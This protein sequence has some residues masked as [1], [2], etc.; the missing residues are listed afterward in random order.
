LVKEGEATSN[1]AYYAAVQALQDAQLLPEELDMILVD[2]ETP[3]HMFPAVSC[4]VQHMLG[5]K[6]IPSFDLYNTC[7]GFLSAL[8]V[9]EQC[10]KLG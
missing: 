8:Q 3:D 1:L 10:I 9:A 6:T 5:C 2:T 4:Q 7:V